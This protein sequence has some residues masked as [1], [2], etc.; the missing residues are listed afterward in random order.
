M[1]LSPILIIFCL[2][3]IRMFF[4]LAKKYDKYLFLHSILGLL[5]F[6]VSYYFLFLISVF[7]FSFAFDKMFFS[8]EIVM[9]CFIIPFALIVSGIHY[10]FLERKFKKLNKKPKISEIGKI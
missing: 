4:L 10:K 9:G 3:I 2:F 5:S 1:I 7:L 8:N 6:L